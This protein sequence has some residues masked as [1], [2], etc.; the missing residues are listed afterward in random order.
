M[1]N[2]SQHKRIVVATAGLCAVLFAICL[3][4]LGA[5]PPQY[6]EPGN[7][8]PRI[9][10]SS[11]TSGVMLALGPLITAW[12]IT[13][14]TRCTSRFVRACII[15]TAT[16]FIV[17]LILVL[18]KY[19]ASDSNPLFLTFCWYYFYFPMILA[20]TTTFVC[21]VYES[22]VSYRTFRMVFSIVA[23][24]DVLLL[25]FLF[26]NNLH[27][28]VFVF[29]YADADWGANY[30]YD[31][32]YWMI[33]GWMVLLGIGFFVTILRAAR[34]RFQGALGLISVLVCLIILYALLYQL[35]VAIAFKSNFAL[36]F[37]L[38][39]LLSFEL[40]LDFG[41][42]P[43]F[44]HHREAFRMLPYDVKVLN[45]AFDVVYR[46][47]SATPLD[48]SMRDLMEMAKGDGPKRSVF[49]VAE[50]PNKAFILWKIRGG[51]VVFGED[52]TTIN[53]GTRLIAVE[54]RALEQGNSLLGHELEVRKKDALLENQMDLAEE[55][56]LSLKSTFSTIELLLHELD[57]RTLD[58]NDPAV[59]KNLLKLRFLIAYSKRKGSLLLAEKTPDDFDQEQTRLVI[60]EFVSDAQAVGI[61][62][63]AFIEQPLVISNKELGALYDCL[64]EI[65]FT[66][67]EQRNPVLLISTAAYDGACT[68]VKVSFECD[69][70]TLFNEHALL[71]LFSAPFDAQETTCDLSSNFRGF[72]FTARMA[73]YSSGEVES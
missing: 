27:H 56:R 6:P 72:I 40:C 19:A 38:F 63:A 18:L 9:F 51:S 57:D 23:C 11:G 64:H 44:S 15:A 24:I 69:N 59:R 48:A 26:T 29:D 4:G 30:T 3:F 67:C 66:A 35:R 54:R 12:M 65:A 49:T 37:I 10:S 39:F 62:C 53:E 17:W 58:I 20:P 2:T 1:G 52:R 41:I 21:A 25:L 42:F 70:E 68:K 16:S 46:T 7:P 31:W 60:N 73:F 71:D 28:S 47:E 45:D 34:T 61:D 8:P 14:K 36:T 50:E 55:V 43:S 33:V 13:V 32:G 5:L 22:A